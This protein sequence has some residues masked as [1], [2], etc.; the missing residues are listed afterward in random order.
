MTRKRLPPTALHKVSVIA[1][2]Q[3]KRD[4]HINNVGCIEQ[5]LLP[6][7]KALPQTC[8]FGA[9]GEQMMFDLRHFHADQANDAQYVRRMKLIGLALHAVGLLL[10]CD[11]S[12]LGVRTSSGFWICRRGDAHSL[13]GPASPPHDAAK[14]QHCRRLQVWI[15]DNNFDVLERK[16]RLT[17]D[18][19]AGCAGSRQLFQT[20]SA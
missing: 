14:I 13:I 20:D 4:V 8:L 10:F 6:H 15:R 12:Y 19:I 7:A 2:S 1:F 16:Q 18:R 5:I 11:R 3:R 9:A 17:I